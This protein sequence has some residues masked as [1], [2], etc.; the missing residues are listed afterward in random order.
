[1]G[2][3]SWVV[4]TS[5][6]NACTMSA[7]TANHSWQQTAQG[8]SGMAH[9]GLIYAGKVL[10]ETAMRLFDDSA[11]IEAAKQEHLERLGGHTY[12]SP[13]PADVKPAPL[14]SE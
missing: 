1:M 12:V 3:V 7:H 11:I 2:D 5:Q 4:P 8:K 9:K 6:F 14:G 10:G 13:I